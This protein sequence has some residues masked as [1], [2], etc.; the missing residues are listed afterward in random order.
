MLPDRNH[1]IL[2]LLLAAAG[3]A[4]AFF[5]ATGAPARG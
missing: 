4:L 2:W 3:F 5:I 1:N